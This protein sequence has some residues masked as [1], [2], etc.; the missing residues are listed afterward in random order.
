MYVVTAYKSIFSMISLVLQTAMLIVSENYLLYLTVRILV[1]TVEDLFVNAYADKKYP[2]LSVKSKVSK[3][4]KRSIYRNVKAL[5]WHK[6]GGVLSRST[7]S[8]LLT[9]F[10]GLSGM[11]KY[12]N[13][14]L[15]IGTVGAFFDVVTGAV[16]SSIGNLGAFD[17]GEKSEKVMRNL[18]F[19]KATFYF[20]CGSI[21]FSGVL[22]KFIYTNIYIKLI[23]AKFFNLSIKFG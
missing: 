4:Y 3:D 7:D 5:V 17:R 12:S 18:Y 14:A 13:Y 10:V 1:L 9:Y 22:I 6:V 11:G 19:F 2:C 15:I 16:S 23:A 8:L 20:F 21:Y